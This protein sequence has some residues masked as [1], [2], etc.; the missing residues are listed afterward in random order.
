MKNVLLLYCMRKRDC[1]CDG[2]C[3]NPRTE[4]RDNHTDCC[5]LSGATFHV[6]NFA[7]NKMNH[8]N[9]N[10][11]MQEQLKAHISRTIELTNEEYE[12]IGSHFNK[13]KF[14]KH[15]YLIQPGE[16]VRHH[17][18]VLSGLLKLVYTADTGKEHIIS[19]AAEDWWES[20][21]QAF[22]MQSSATM[23]LECIEDT[24]VLCLTLK[25]YQILCEKSH[26]M[27]LFFLQKANSGFIAAQQRIISTMTS[28]ARARFEQVQK[29]YPFLV[30]R[31]PKRLLAAY[32]G[33]SRETLSRLHP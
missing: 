10:E 3:Y 7:D 18:F 4:I 15:Q 11:P 16:P 24:E 14:K 27:A 31:V 32:I 25:D 33:V 21:F 9:L 17:Y 28:E 30:Q 22:F 23:S 19:F 8:I 1:P 12:F 2:F 5:I 6:K 13:R 26:K 20:D 29:R